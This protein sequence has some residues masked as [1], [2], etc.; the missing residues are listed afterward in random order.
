MKKLLCLLLVMI[1]AVV[2]ASNALA[3]TEDDFMKAFEAVAASGDITCEKG[4][5]TEVDEGSM[6]FVIT[7]DSIADI[8]VYL[9][10][11]GSVS[12]L[13]TSMDIQNDDVDPTPLAASLLMLI[14]SCRAAAS[15]ETD[16]DYSAITVEL[17]AVTDLL[18][19]VQPENLPFD[20]SVE[21]T[22]G[23]C[24]VEVNDFGGG[25]YQITLQFTPNF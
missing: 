18:A 16:L 19:G 22:D 2:C 11:D 1:F 12:D 5:H 24:R 13:M 21:L 4:E 3:L 23:T 20:E 7:G 14:V 25:E 15:G 8:T 17:T 6:G 10:D 9:N